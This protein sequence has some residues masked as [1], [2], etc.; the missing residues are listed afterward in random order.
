MS[1]LRSIRVVANRWL[2]VILLGL[3]AGAA[4]VPAGARE[5]DLDASFCHAVTDVRQADD[6]LAALRFTCGGTP[7][8]YQ[9]GSLWLRAS[10]DQ[11]SVQRGDA[12]LMVHQSRFDRLAVAFTFADGATVWQS[13]RSGDFGWH[14]RAGGQIAFEPPDRG[15][16]LVAI[17]MRFDRLA[18]H[19]LLH[20]RLIGRGESDIQSVALAAS[21]GA[22]L[23]LLLVGGLYNLSLSAA[24]R[25][26]YL[27]WQ[28]AWAMCM[29]LWGTCWSQLH[30]LVLPGMAGSA[31]AQICTFFAFL[32]IVLATVGAVTAID[33]SALPRVLRIGT[34]ALA[35]AI[36]AC[37]VPLTLMRSVD[38]LRLAGV[39]NLLI[40]AN[41]LAVM[42]CLGVAVRR[43]SREARDFL[44]SWSVPMAALAFVTLVDIDSLFWGA[45]S[46][47]FVLM[48][49]TWQTLWLSIAAT[50]RLAELRVER[51]HARAAEAHAH[52]L[53]RRD[54]LTGLRNRRGFIE[55]VG[56]LLEQV[57]DHGTPVALL[58]IDIDRFKSINDQHGHEAGD[59]VL[60]TI[61]RRLER[62]EGSMGT[63]ARLGGEEFGLVMTG[64]DG[65]ALARF[66]DSVRC[67]IAACD[68]RAVLGERLVTA[69]IGIAEAL[70]SSDFQQL[71]RMA[72]EALYEAKRSGRDRVSLRTRSGESVAV[73]QAE[74]LQA[75]S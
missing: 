53:A 51:D 8:G 65:F 23:T 19:E 69:S 2:A 30:L 33:R 67:E 37:G 25:R 44:F 36:G 22:A 47:I 29:L 1:V 40:L 16:P 63:A 38:L 32:A 64:L 59:T 52:E 11:L 18:S 62:W 72:D 14:W 6:R 3:L 50:R 43:G 13:V 34:L 24:V 10:V 46:K 9:Q 60:C 73:P 70:P 12:A 17:T 7:E 75:N 68:H 27:A 55:V 39:T 58:L 49:A 74:R 31:T 57:R 20:I 71:Y 45:G 66:A 28:G 41:L 15:V 42:I 4:S 35:V 61:A 21:V 26:Q 5:L 48:A 54:P 56:P